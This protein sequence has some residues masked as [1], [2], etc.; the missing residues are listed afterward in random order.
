MCLRI[1]IIF[2]SG[3][4]GSILS[5]RVKIFVCTLFSRG[6]LHDR[7]QQLGFAYQ[8]YNAICRITDK[9]AKRNSQFFVEKNS[10]FHAKVKLLN[11]D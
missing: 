10:Q 6:S 4:G 3:L 7:K 5:K 1:P 11:S 9:Y 2:I 8:F